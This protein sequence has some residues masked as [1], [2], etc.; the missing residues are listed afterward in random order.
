MIG[1]LSNTEGGMP[2]VLESDLLVT[3][4]ALWSIDDHIEV[5]EHVWGKIIEE[6]LPSINQIENAHLVS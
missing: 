4:S 2:T 6:I 3:L 1:K 5:L